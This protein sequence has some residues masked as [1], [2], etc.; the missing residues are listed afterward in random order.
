M[1]I[2]DVQNTVSNTTCNYFFVVR[3]RAL[4]LSSLERE[5]HFESGKVICKVVWLNQVKLKKISFFKIRRLSPQ[6]M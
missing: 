6:N 3:D 2:I 4:V 1:S 5:I